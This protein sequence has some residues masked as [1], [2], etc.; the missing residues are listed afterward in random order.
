MG[1]RVP[2]VVDS[3]GLG[4]HVSLVLMET[5]AWLEI[6]TVPLVVWMLVGCLLVGCLLA[7]CLLVGC[8]LVGCLLVIC[9]LVPSVS[10]VCVPVIRPFVVFLSVVCRSAVDV[11]PVR[12]L[13][14]HVL[15]TTV[16]FV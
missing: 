11:L 1:L 2:T 12:G 8:L 15:L 10:V 4:D 3:P 13:V 7:G 16:E 9:R 5:E 6:V 14:D